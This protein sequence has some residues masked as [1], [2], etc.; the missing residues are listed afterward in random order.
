M[1]ASTSTRYMP[2]FIIL[3]HIFR[4]GDVC[5]SAAYVVRILAVEAI[6]GE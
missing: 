4:T 1:S 6:L 3:R 2:G 5:Y